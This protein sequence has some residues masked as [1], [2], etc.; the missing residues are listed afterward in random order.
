MATAGEVLEQ[1][2]RLVGIDN[3]TL[4][5]VVDWAAAQRRKHDVK[6]RLLWAL[7]ALRDGQTL[8]LVAS[9]LEEAY[10]FDSAR[11]TALDLANALLTPHESEAA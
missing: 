10:A 5:A 8:P 11:T 3:A 1:M 4:D 9:N 7:V 6:A 2:Q